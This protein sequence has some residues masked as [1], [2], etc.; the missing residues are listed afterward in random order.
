MENPSAARSDMR[1]YA[2][3]TERNREPILEVLKQVLS[4]GDT[5][6]GAQGGAQ[7]GAQSGTKG[8]T[9][10][11]TQRGT[12]LEIAS[13]TGEHAAFFAPRLPHLQWLPSE[14]QAMMRESIQAWTKAVASPANLLPV[15]ALEV[16]QRPWPVEVTI[17]TVPI[18]AVVNIN[19]I[20]ISEWA[21]SG[22]LMAGAQRVLTKDGL[23]Y[24]Y[25][26]FKREGQHTAPSNEAFDGML[27]DRNPAWGIRDLEAIIELAAAHQLA[28]EQLISMPAN[29]FS[30]T[31]RRQ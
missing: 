5:Q 28:F 26:P 15:L 17:P 7:G 24:L 12:V 2:P 23:L 30:V 20:H 29:N 19:M 18:C 21:M 6:S 1:Q 10:G 13:G 4:Q 25:G 31:F 9:K 11:D 3:A 14:P 27:R 8:D 22:H 16:S